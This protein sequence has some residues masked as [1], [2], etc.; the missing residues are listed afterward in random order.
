MRR[1]ADFEGEWVIARDIEDRLGGVPGRFD[2]VARF[3]VEPWGL[4][5]AEG[6]ELRLGGGAALR[7]TRRYRWILGGEGVD[8]FYSD[9][10]YFHAFH[11]EAAEAEHLCGDDLYR[12]RYGFGDWPEWVAEWDVRGP[13]KDYRMRSTYRRA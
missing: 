9:G 10:R 4:A 11:W 5:Y 8:V 13:R 12:V 1:A 3:T 7:A 2:G 6:G